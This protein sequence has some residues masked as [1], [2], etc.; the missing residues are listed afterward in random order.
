MNKQLR[1]IHQTAEQRGVCLGCG[2]THGEC[3]CKAQAETAT[4]PRIFD[5]QRI[6]GRVTAWFS[7]DQC[8]T[9]I[10]APKDAEIIRC[11]HCNYGLR[12]VLTKFTPP[13][14]AELELVAHITTQLP[15]RARRKPSLNRA[16]P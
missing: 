16:R 2:G 4:P 5:D 6:K 1:A 3:T 14:P 15:R 10:A 11:G 12:V 9:V 8:K 7:C 13:A